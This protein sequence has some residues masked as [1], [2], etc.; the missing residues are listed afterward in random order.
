MA[1]GSTRTDFF[2]AKFGEK[3]RVPRSGYWTFYL[4]VNDAAY[5]KINGQK[6]AE[7]RC[8]HMLSEKSGTQALSAGTHSIEVNYTPFTI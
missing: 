3:L 2:L 7:N 5:L 6:V 8:C 1:D 4:G